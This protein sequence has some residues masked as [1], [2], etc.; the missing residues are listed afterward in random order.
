[1]KFLKIS[2]FYFFE[3]LFAIKIYYAIF[4]SVL[5]LLAF[6]RISSGGNMSSSGLE[7]ATVIFMFVVGLD[8]FKSDFYFS[9]SVSVSRKTFLKGLM[10]GILRIS[11]LM[12]VIDVILNRIYN[13]FVPSPTMFDMLYTAYRDTGIMNYRTLEFIWKQSNEIYI[14]LSTFVWQFAL[15]TF[16]CLAGLLITLIYYRSNKWMRVVVSISPVFFFMLMRGL[17]N[18]LI[19]FSGSIISFMDKAFGYSNMNPYMAVI[20]FLVAGGILSVFIYLLTRK[21]E[22]KE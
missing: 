15:Y 9:Q 16:V 11:M 20:T 7:F 2:K 1:M 4:I 12:S 6:S 19:D 22:I 17:G 10:L 14:L 3:S 13:L 21:A 18:Y 5:A 8:S